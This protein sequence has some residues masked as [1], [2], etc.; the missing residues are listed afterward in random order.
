METTGSKID[1]KMFNDYDIFKLKLPKDLPLSRN[2]VFS[3][4]A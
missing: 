4:N 2:Q 1:K 3:I